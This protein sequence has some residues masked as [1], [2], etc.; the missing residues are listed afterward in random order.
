[1]DLDRFAR[2][3]ILCRPLSRQGW[4]PVTGKQAYKLAKW[5][6][7]LATST[8]CQLGQ[9]VNSPGHRAYCHA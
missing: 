4:N 5:L 3:L 9:Y 1:M 6:A 7:Q 2:E 8:F